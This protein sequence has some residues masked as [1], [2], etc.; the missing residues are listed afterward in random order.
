MIRKI[1]LI[2]MLLFVSGSF[3]NLYGDMSVEV[4][5]F[6]DSLAPYG[7]WIYLDRYGVW[8]WKPVGLWVGWQ[9]YTYG[10]WEWSEEYGWIW[11]SYFEWGWAPFHY[12]RWFYDEYYGWVWVP[13]TVWRPHWVVWVQYG[14]YIGWFP[15]YPSFVYIDYFSPVVYERWVIIEATNITSGNYHHY[16][17]PEG[18][19]GEIFSNTS[20]AHKFIPREDDGSYHNYSPPK[21]EIEKVTNRKIEPIKP[22]FVDKPVNIYKPSERKF[23]MYKPEFKSKIPDMGY[24]KAKEI[25][26]APAGNIAGKSVRNLPGSNGDNGFKPKYTVPLGK[27][28]YGRGYEG[29]YGAF[30]EFNK[31]AGHRSGGSPYI[32]DSPGSDYTGRGGH[33]FDGKIPR[34]ESIKSYSPKKGQGIFSPKSDSDDSG[35]DDSNYKKS[36]PKL[37]PKNTTVPKLTPQFKGK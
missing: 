20:G 3:S 10:R 14:T 1:V 18:K 13:G 32:Y 24:L 37:S 27:Y 8:V 36:I 12:G 26:K 33:H 29:N 15:Y 16:V 31:G 25:M 28:Q 30:K 21:S 34:E 35:D 17:L 5:I 9:P 11:V 4:G 6:Y 19:R 23:V 7:D 22:E 2:F